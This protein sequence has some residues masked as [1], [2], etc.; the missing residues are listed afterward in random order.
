MSWPLQPFL[1]DAT[2]DQIGMTDPRGAPML[3]DNA[4]LAAQVPVAL[5]RRGCIGC[6]RG[7]GAEMA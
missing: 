7:Y 4:A 2:Y 6:G 1:V 5:S 3:Q